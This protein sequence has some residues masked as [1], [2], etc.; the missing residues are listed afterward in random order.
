MTF[1]SLK[2]QNI[3]YFDMFVINFIT[4]VFEFDR[5]D[6]RSYQ[7]RMILNL[8]NVGNMIFSLASDDFSLT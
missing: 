3:Y 1:R 2:H 5:F 7:P 8:S 6:L 4:S